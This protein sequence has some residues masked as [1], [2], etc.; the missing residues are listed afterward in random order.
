MKSRTLLFGA[1]Q[2]S[3][4]YMENNHS[5][6]DFI[7]F[8]DNDDRKHGTFFEGLPVYS[9]DVLETLSFDEIV[10]STQWAMEVQQQLIEK[11]GIAEDKVVLPQKNQLK[12]ITPF[13]HPQTMSL[14]RK[15]VKTI[16]A[17]ALDG[18]TPIVIDFGTLLGIVRDNDLIEWDD[19]IDFA[20]PLECCAE[21]E[22]LLLDYIASSAS[23]VIWRLEK[24]ADT[25]GN[26][27]GL[28][29]KF[30]DP[31][32]ELVEFTTSFSFRKNIDGKSIH[33]PSLGMWFAPCEHFDGFSTIDWC[34]SEI[35]VP[36]KHLEYLTFQYGDWQT[37]KKDIQLSDY[38]NLQTVEFADIQ[39]ASFIATEITEPASTLKIKAND[40]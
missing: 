8:L 20:A 31:D 38:A 6:R 37:P 18:N 1:G 21:V 19:D 23:K 24:V 36:I 15:I 26:V 12:K 10:I 3:R 28:L 29:L 11:M 25:D 35:P 22:A 30:T 27:S 9:P 2:G 39:K 33:M 5:S 16:S 32:G 34:G 7:G 14:G 13:E 17:S 40:R 4:Q